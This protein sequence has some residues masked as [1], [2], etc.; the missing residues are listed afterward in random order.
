MFAQ[1]EKSV[2]ARVSASGGT[3]EVIARAK[4]GELVG[5]PEVLPGGRFVL[6]SVTAGTA[7]DWDKG[8]LVVHSLESGEER[9]VVE[10]AS[11]A[12][13]LP[14]GHLVYAK[15]GVLFA[16]PFDAAA[17]ETIVSD[18]RSVVLNPKTRTL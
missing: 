10:A 17:N 5:G 9:T 1:A 6:F 12:H 3:P 2:I 15:E 16:A 7:G 8:R 14:T 4:Q 18:G 11:D 13:Y